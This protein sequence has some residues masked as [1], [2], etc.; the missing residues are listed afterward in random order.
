MI[1]RPDVIFGK[2]SWRFL[3]VSTAGEEENENDT[4]VES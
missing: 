3:N 4:S 1:Y 2:D